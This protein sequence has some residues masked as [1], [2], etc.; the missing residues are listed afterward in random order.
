MPALLLFLKPLGE[1]ILAFVLKRFAELLT[2]YFKKQAKKKEEAAKSEKAQKEFKEEYQKAVE[3]GDEKA[4]K[5][6][7]KKLFD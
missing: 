7:Y 3:A 2:D 5:D 1:W 4:Q 6:A